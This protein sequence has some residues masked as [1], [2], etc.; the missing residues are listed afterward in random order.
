MSFLGIDL[1]TGSLKAAIVDEHGREQAVSSVAYAL[2][3]PHSGWAEIAVETWWNALVDATA[4]LP[5]ELRDGV[6]A[7][8]FSGQMHGV[9]LLDANGAAVRRAASGSCSTSQRSS[10]PAMPG[11]AR[12]GRCSRRTGCAS[13][14]AARA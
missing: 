13:R 11:A 14:S 2:V 9:V 7:I 8:G 4:R 6:R 3:T 1:G 10:G 12:A 5:R